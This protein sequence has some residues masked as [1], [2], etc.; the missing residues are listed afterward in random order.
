VPKSL[1]ILGGG[2]VA[3]AFATIFSRLGAAVTLLEA[4]AQILPEVDRELVSM[5]ERDLKKDKIQVFTEARVEAVQAGSG[6]GAERT[7]AFSHKGEKKTLTV[8]TVLLADGR[9][10]NVEGFGLDK[11]GVRIE[12]GSIVVNGRMETSVPGI[13]AA[14]DVVGGPLLAHVAVTEGKTAAE[15]AMGGDKQMDY[16]AVPRCINTAP[17]LASLGLTEARAKEE[18]YD[19]RIGRFSFGANGMATILGERTGTVKVITDGK[20]GQIL[21]VHI[22]GPQASNLIPEAALAMKLDATP[23]EIATTIHAHPTLS[24]ALME[25]ALDVNGDTLHSISANKK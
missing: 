13:F 22:I 21:G 7:V 20:Y 4:S 24:E 8:Q 23:V 2:D 5:L 3:L 25:A 17:E 18:G 12:G 16:T 15:N 10:A 9:K 6:A 11:V 19:L 1:A 14:G